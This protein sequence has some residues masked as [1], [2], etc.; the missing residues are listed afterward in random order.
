MKK[1]G[2]VDYYISEWHANNYPRWIEDASKALGTEYKVAYVWAERE[3]SPV[4]GKSTDE[5]CKSFGAERCESIN[6]LCERSDAII[7]LAPSNPEKHLKYASE[8]LKHNKLTYIDKTFADNYGEAL[9]IF[10]LSEKYKTKFFTSSALRYSDAVS[11]MYE[12]DYMITSGGGSNLP[13]YIIHQCEMVAAVMKSEPVSVSV[14]K[15]GE[16]YICTAALASGKGAKM[17][18]SPELNF[19]AS[20]KIGERS[21]LLEAGSSFFPKLI[22]TILKFFENGIL[23][24]DSSETLA[25]MKLRDAVLLATQGLD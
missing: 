20:Y 1:I 18:Y 12:P 3:I 25:V 24:F 9:E 13:E 6:E 22:L 17:I 11:I 4:D 10:K 2:F 19:S 7:V 23:P 15:D 8:V 16:K 14:E 21:E 5:W